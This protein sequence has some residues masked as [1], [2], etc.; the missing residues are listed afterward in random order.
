MSHL[1]RLKPDSELSPVLVD[2]ELAFLQPATREGLAY[3][4]SLRKG[5]AIPARHELRPRAMQRFLEHV[6]LVDVVADQDRGFDYVIGLQGMH[7][8]NVF[9]HMAGRRLDA[10]MRPELAQRWRTSF[11]LPRNAA[12]PVRVFT[13][14]SSAGKNWL[15]CEALLAPL[16]ESEG[17]IDA[18]FWVFACW[19][20]E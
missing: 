5:R 12:A 11:D 20:A 3:W 7:A 16:G 2:W 4:Q 19:P 18:L 8:R 1:A 17:R 15:A 9:G 13:R 6:N 10:I 14:A